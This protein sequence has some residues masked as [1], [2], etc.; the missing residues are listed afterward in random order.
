M[1]KDENR[2]A[3]LEKLFEHIAPMEICRLIDEMFSEL[4]L[5]NDQLDRNNVD[6]KTSP[7]QLNSFFYNLNQVKECLHDINAFESTIK[8][9]IGKNGI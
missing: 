7:S 1:T 5:I 4:L 6:G 2:L 9:K 3:Q 8:N